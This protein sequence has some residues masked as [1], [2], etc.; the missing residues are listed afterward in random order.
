MAKSVKHNKAPLTLA[1]MM[2][3]EPIIRSISV[4]NFKSF[5]AVKVDLGD[6]NVL[7]GANEAGKSNFLEVFA[8][9]RDAALYGVDGAIATQGGA[10]YLRNAQIGA[11]RPLRVSCEM[12]Y[13]HAPEVVE[14][15]PGA[16]MEVARVKYEFAIEF[17]KRGREFRVVD[18][19]Q[20]LMGT[21]TEAGEPS[22]GRASKS[23]T[24]Q[25]VLANQGGQL[26]WEAS[27]SDGTALQVGDLLLPF[28]SGRTLP[29]KELL[30]GYTYF[31]PSASS[32]LLP[33]LREIAIYDLNPRLSK[34]MATTT[35]RRAMQ[36]DGSNL[37]V[38]LE[39]I[40][41][42]DESRRQLRNFLH[43]LLP[44]VEDVAVERLADHSVSWRLRE[45]FTEDQFLP[46]YT[47][48]DGTVQITALIIALYFENK[49]L[50]II[51][52]PDRHVHP[53]L[54]SRMVQMMRDVADHRQVIVTTHNP[55]LIK[56]VGIENILL[57]SRD[58][59]GFSQ[60]TRPADN[61]HLKVFLKNEI[62]VDE[63]FV[64]NLLEV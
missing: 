63:L 32:V 44:F 54:A 4:S 41:E 19:R 35:G 29:D 48:S 8:F 58:H 38:A 15:G 56:H 45:R 51:E 6:F 43:D 2:P 31:S 17:D 37:A 60:I 3:I 14:L 64:Q 49:D 53:S 20:T 55:E 50:V 42:D 36:Q 5:D 23:G 16:T 30:L 1:Q 47:L 52:E 40:L 26:R 46:A 9:L 11:R 12:G 25:V 59:Q 34:G 62:G 61:E 57:I 22:S 21:V 27:F 33:F 28:W 10:E 39:E 13:R 24:A 7:V 18:D